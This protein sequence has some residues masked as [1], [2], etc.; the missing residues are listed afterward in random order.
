MD[1]VSKEMKEYLSEAAVILNKEHIETSESTGI[2][3][4]YHD[5]LRF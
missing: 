4:R 2:V 1:H 5:P 3:E